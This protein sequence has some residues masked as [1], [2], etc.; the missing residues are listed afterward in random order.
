MSMIPGITHL[1]SASMTLEQPAV[2]RGDGD[3]AATRPSRIPMLRIADGPPVPS[4]HP[5]FAITVWKVNAPTSLDWTAYR[6]CQTVVP[7]A[8]A[9]K[10]ALRCDDW[11]SQPEGPVQPSGAGKHVALHRC[12][13]AG[14]GRS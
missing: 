5:P 6:S 7:Q 9:A 4:N 1:P 10:P 11:R 12:V 14:L 13:L 3:T 8:V 2:S